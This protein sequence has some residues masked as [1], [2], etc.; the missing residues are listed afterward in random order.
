[1]L[2]RP[3]RLTQLQILSHEYKVCHGAGHA[4]A[5]ATIPQHGP[6]CLSLWCGSTVV[7][8]YG[9]MMH[10]HVIETAAAMPA[11]H[12]SAARLHRAQIASR[13]EVFVAPPDA[14]GSAA[15]PP[16][17]R[18][19]GFLSLDANEQSGH[20][21]CVLPRRRS[22]R[23]SCPA[24]VRGAAVK[25]AY[26][27]SPHLCSCGVHLYTDVLSTNILTMCQMA[28]APNAEASNYSWPSP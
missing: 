3:A 4:L 7:W 16:A 25:G 18:R 23:A 2:D 17:W 14:I 27:C 11:C 15:G 20:Q 10:Q 9:Q 8:L 26:L 24:I 28:G 22:S 19:L 12:D 13:V 6:G 21:V 1:M 5:A